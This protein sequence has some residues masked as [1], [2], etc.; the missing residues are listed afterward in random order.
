MRM[1]RQDV[2]Q[3]YAANTRSAQETSRLSWL[4]NRQYASSSEYS[5]ELRVPNQQT[6]LLGTFASDLPSYYYLVSSLLPYIAEPQ[7]HYEDL[8]FQ[9]LQSLRQTLLWPSALLPH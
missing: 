5:T 8:Y 9:R 3:M 6:L 2:R 4:V 1:L 7:P